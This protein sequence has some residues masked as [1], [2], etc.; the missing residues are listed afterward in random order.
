MYGRFKKIMGK[1]DLIKKFN[2]DI[3]KLKR[4]QEK[5]AKSLEI[6]DAFDFELVE[7]VAGIDSI[8]IKGMI[9]SGVVVIN[10]DFEILEEEYF[11]DKAKFPYI[12]GFRAYRELPT[13]IEAFNKL[14]EKP[15]LVFIKGHGILHPRSLGLASHFSLATGTPSIGIADSLIVGEE[16][17]GEIYLNNKLVGKRI[18]TKEGA[19]P[20]FVSPGNKI[21]VETSVK[22]TEEFHKEPHKMPEPLRLARKYVKEIQKEIYG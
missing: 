21:S 17:N 15:D 5:L 10:R 16:K 13:M 11:Q 2:I 22:L 8:F 7:K 1:E 20:I 3:E 12:P 18:K 4:E 19:K 9:I 14:S 6:K